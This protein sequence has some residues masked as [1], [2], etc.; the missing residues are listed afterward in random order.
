MDK[1]LFGRRMDEWGGWE[2]SAL[3]RGAQQQQSTTSR[4]MENSEECVCVWKNMF[5]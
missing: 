5:M 2:K 3:L 1:Q 4:K